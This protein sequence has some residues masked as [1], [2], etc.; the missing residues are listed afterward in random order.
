MDVLSKCTIVRA[1]DRS[2]YSSRQNS[3]KKQL[4]SVSVNSICV[5]KTS[6]LA[7]N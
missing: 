1:M 6:N 4:R 3:Q 7:R 2:A 5:R